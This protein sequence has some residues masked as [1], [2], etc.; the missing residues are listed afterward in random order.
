[1]LYLTAIDIVKLRL[2]GDYHCRSI[3]FFAK[4]CIDK[5]QGIRCVCYNISLVVVVELQ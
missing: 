4:N 2:V 3:H 5:T 1:M